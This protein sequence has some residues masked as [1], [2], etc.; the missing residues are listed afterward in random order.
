MYY[1]GPLWL[2]RVM[3]SKVKNAAIIALSI[4]L[5]LSASVNIYVLQY[6]ITNMVMPSVSQK[7]I[8]ER[9]DQLNRELQRTIENLRACRESAQQCIE[10]VESSLGDHKINR[11]TRFRQT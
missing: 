4:L 11:L 6:Q 8:Y 5:L 2:D 7:D 10:G 9:C 3:M 1:R